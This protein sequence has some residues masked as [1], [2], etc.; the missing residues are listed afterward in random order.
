L[1]CVWQRI[2]SPIIPFII[3]DLITALFLMATASRLQSTEHGIC[4][5]HSPTCNLH[6][7]VFDF[8]HQY[9]SLLDEGIIAAED[10]T[11]A[12]QQPMF[13]GRERG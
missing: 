3:F 5:Q 1:A 2:A 12:Q 11:L 6:P 13:E 8:M 9:Y 10:K 4:H 7:S